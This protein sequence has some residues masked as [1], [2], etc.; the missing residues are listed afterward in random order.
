MSIKNVIEQNLIG[1]SKFMFIFDGSYQLVFGLAYLG[2]GIVPIW[3][4]NQMVNHVTNIVLAPK[5]VLGISQIGVVADAK[6]PLD[7]DTNLCV[8]YLCSNQP[9]LQLSM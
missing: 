6:N 2:T 1:F 4:P 3:P 8:C 7:D 5:H 9:I